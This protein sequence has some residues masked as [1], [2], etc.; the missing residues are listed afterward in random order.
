MRSILNQVSKSWL[1]AVDLEVHRL[2]NGRRLPR[3]LGSRFPS[4]SDLDLESCEP[5]TALRN[6]LVEALLELPR[7]RSL[8][9]LNDLSVVRRLA[10]RKTAE[11][12][13]KV[14]WPCCSLDC[15]QATLWTVDRRSCR[16]CNGW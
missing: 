14:R 9:N 5:T 8:L 16:F 3:N 11:D 2:S 13:E 15:R 7:L 10:G 4:L 1:V 6:H 12:V